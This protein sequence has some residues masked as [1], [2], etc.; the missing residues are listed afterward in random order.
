MRLWGLL[1]CL[2]EF[3]KGRSS[4]RHASVRVIV[5]AGD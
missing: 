3:P 1:L 5:T 2:V 4:V